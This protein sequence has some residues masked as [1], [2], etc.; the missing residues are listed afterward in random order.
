MYRLKVDVNT[1]LGQIPQL[2]P[3]PNDATEYPFTSEKYNVLKVIL[4]KS[5]QVLL[6]N[7]RIDDIFK[8]IKIM[9]IER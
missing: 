2:P 5:L 4:V 3:S 1:R 9:P 6:M 8:N 7:L